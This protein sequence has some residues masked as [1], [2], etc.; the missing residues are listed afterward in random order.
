MAMKEVKSKTGETELQPPEHVPP[1]PIKIT[2]VG[3]A[4][5]IKRLELAEKACDEL[6]KETKWLHEKIVT[7][8]KQIQSLQ[9]STR[10]RIG[11]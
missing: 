9:L 6:I 8:A 11:E 7:Q 10:G 4:D 2:G 3:R 5:L 1:G